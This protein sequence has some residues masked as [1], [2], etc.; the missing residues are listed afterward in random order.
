M[1]AYQQL[2]NLST[3]I[4]TLQGISNILGWDQETY[5]P[6]AG[7]QNRGEQLKTMAGLIH[8]EKTSKEYTAALAKLVDLETGE[9]LAKGLEDHQQAA[10][11]EWHR[12]YRHDTALP[13]AF[14]EEFAQLTSQAQLIWSKAKDN[15]AFHHFAPFLDKLVGMSRKKANYLGYQDHP[16]DALIDLY[17]PNFSTKDVAALFSDLKNSL[18]PLLKQIQKKNQV[19]DSFLYGT[20]SIPKQLSF[21]KKLLK[22]IGYDME[23][24]RLDFSSH[25]FSSASHPTD[26]RITT[27]IDRRFVPGNIAIVLHEAGHSLYEMGLPIE[28]FGTPLGEAISLGMHESQSRWWETRIGRSLPFWEHYFPLLQ[29]EFKG[30]LNDI[31]LE[32]F[33]KGINKVSPSFIRVEADEVTYSLH[34][35]LRFEMEKALIEGSLKVRDVPEAWNAKMAD[36][37]G[38]VP[39]THAQGCLQDVHWSMGAFGYFPSYTLGNLYA[40]HMFEAFEKGHPEWSQNIAKGEFGFMLEWLHTNVHQYGRQY[41]SPELLQKITGKPFTAD[42]FVKYLT[43]KYAAIYQ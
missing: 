26:S 19:D 30:K 40:S 33:Y 7:G 25:P 29:R 9:I 32:T 2:H 13:Q 28:Q 12:D 31:S 18:V 1:E 35:I 11:R 10:L 22:D 39:Q 23:K 21:A 41:N 36:L 4:K 20:F 38:I 5:M 8:K 43:K 17:E 15:N 24:G 27:R 42:A 14:V 16:Y 3:H 37:F 6:P 34:V